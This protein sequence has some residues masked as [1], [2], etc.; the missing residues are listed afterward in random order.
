MMEVFDAVPK[1]WGNSIG[2]TIPKAIIERENI[3]TKNKI[4][5]IVYGDNSKKLKN[6]FGSLKIKKSGQ[7]IMDEIDVGYR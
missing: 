5:I 3:S 7:E 1:E 2:V 6:I 4:R